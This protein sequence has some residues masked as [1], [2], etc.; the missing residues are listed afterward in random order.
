MALAK[1]RKIKVGLYTFQWKISPRGGMHLAVFHIPSKTK[2]VYWMEDKT[3][4]T[5]RMVREYIEKM[6]IESPIQL[7]SSA[8]KKGSVKPKIYRPNR[9]NGN[10]N[11]NGC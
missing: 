11:H 9:F 5:P 10:H 8:F 7:A 1:A 6:L 4:V 2:W 3:I